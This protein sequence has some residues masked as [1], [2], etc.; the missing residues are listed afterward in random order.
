VAFGAE[1]VAP[2]PKAPG[3]S[4]AA[5]LLGEADRAM[6]LVGVLGHLAGGLAGADLGRGDGERR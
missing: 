2:R 4:V 6:H 1:F 5:V 3:Q